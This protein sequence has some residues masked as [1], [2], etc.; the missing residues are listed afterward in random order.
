VTR[1]SAGLLLY[2]RGDGGTVE[3]LLLHLGGPLWAA[4]DERAWTFPKGEL[5]P[6]EDPATAAAREFAEE[7]GRPPPPGPRRDLG[8]VRQPGGKVTRMWAVPGDLD[9]AEVRSGTFTMQWPPRSGRSAEFPEIDRAEWFPLEGA[10]VKLV[11]SLVP[12]LDR[13][14]EVVEDR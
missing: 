4:R 2:R 13:L 3:V 1:R 11:A 14:L 7:T 5:E 8:E 10:R 9:A 12:F 6:G